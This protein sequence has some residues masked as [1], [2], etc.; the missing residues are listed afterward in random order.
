LAF[1]GVANQIAT[2]SFVQ[3][4]NLLAVFDKPQRDALATLLINID[5]QG[6]P[7]SELFWGL[8]LL[9]LAWLVYLG[10]STSLPWRVVVFEWYCICNNKLHWYAVAGTCA[11]R[12]HGKLSASSRRSSIFTLVTDCWSK[13]ESTLQNSA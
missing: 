9:P 7:V 1:L 6:V 5:R 8:W 10:L 11:D 3:G 12:Q 4:S 13:A 2:L